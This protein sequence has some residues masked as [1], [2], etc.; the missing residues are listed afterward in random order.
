MNI[1]NSTLQANFA[2]FLGV[3]A[4]VRHSAKLS[5][6]NSTF[7]DNLANIYGAG[8]R[9]LQRLLDLC[10]QNVA[11]MH[12]VLTDAVFIVDLLLVSSSLR[13][14]TCRH[15]GTAARTSCLASNA[16]NFLDV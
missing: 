8:T 9:L 3:A 1:T 5:I 11:H 14:C 10:N 4:F 13:L 12:C 15:L 7:A 2:S 6:S 16:L